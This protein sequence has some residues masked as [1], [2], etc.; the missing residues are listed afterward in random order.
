MLELHNV[1]FSAGNKVLLDNVNL[2]T[3]AGS[4]CGLLGPNGAGKSTVLKAISRDIQAT[5]SIK[6]HGKALEEWN[7]L[8]RAK[9]LAVLPQA[10]QLTFPFS[11]QE[12]VALGLTPLSISRQQ[13][14]QLI[15]EKM[16]LTDCAGLADRSYPSLSGGERQRVQLARVLLQ[17][18][19]AEQ[20]PLLLLDEPTS[21]QD[22]GQQHNI[23]ALT[24]ELAKSHNFAIVTIL[25]D[26]NQV[27]RYCDQCYLLDQGQVSMQGPPEQVLSNQCIREHWQYDPQRVTL[28]NG[29][30]ALI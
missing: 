9:H 24:Q 27:L 20:A 19:Q 23:L 30:L 18:S 14:E 3:H 16:Y 28:S 13:A 26:L 15:K 17:L 10:S 12:V 21:A 5:G 25:H 29:Q 2:T 22:L 6:F 8:E 4:V 11:A 1:C 7:D